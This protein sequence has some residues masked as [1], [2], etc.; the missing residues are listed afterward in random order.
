M[1]AHLGESLASIQ[2]LDTPMGQTTTPSLEA[3]RAFAL[4]DV[5][6][7]KGFDLPQAEG[8]Y[9]QAIAIDPNFAMAWARLGVVDAN[10]GQRRKALPAFQRAYDLS[11]S[12]SERERLYIQGHFYMNATGNLENAVN[13]LDLAE[14]TYPLD[15]SN[16]INLGSAQSLLLGLARAYVLA[17]DR[18]NVQETY[19]DPFL[20][21][22]NP[23]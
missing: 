2:K 10:A 15:I 11:K 17:G 21:S 3:F 20:T 14:K 4:G 6:H 18:A 1:R 22:S 7:E 23:V 13:T 9:K 5:E 12:V 8:H 16:P 19:A